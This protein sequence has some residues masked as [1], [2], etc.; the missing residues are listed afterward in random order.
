MPEEER[1]EKGK[2]ASSVILGGSL[3]ILGLKIDLGKLLSAPEELAGRLEGLRE[4]L[5]AAGGKETLS[6]EEWRQGGAVVTGHIRVR[7]LSGEREYHVGTLG[8]TGRQPAG[9]PPGPPEAVEPPVDVFH[10]AGQVAVVADV[11]GV[12]LDDLSVK[13]EGNILAISTKVGARRSYQ[14]TV[15]LEGDLEPSSLT[16]TCR[17]GVLEVRLR[18]RSSGKP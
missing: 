7:D 18:K 10:E 2:P 11:P 6:D 4:K 14:K 16:A 9:Q 1:K 13:L 12:E 15:P 17:N 5:K 8:R 3:D